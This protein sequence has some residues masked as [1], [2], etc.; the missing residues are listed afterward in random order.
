MAGKRMLVIDDEVEIGNFI[1]V[2]GERSG[3]DVSVVTDFAAFREALAA[4]EPALIVSD[5][6]M[7]QTDGIELLKFLAKSECR[8]PI[9]I[10]SGVDTRL[11]NTALRFGKANGLR[12]L[13]TLEKP[14]RVND[15]LA[16]LAALEA[17]GPSLDENGLRAAIDNH[18]L[19]L[20]YQPKIELASGRVVGAEA[21]VRW[22]IPSGGLFAPMEF[23]PLAEKT[24]LIRPLTDSVLR[25]AIR[26]C[27]E[28]SRA[29]H[30]LSAAINL[31]PAILDDPDLP[32]EIARLAAAEGLPSGRLLLE[33][34]ES[35]AMAD[36]V[37][38]MEI[39][40]R[41]RLKG[42]DLAIDD[43]GTGFS[44]LVALAR[45]PFSEIKIDKSF[46]LEMRESK[47][48]EVIV[49]SVVDLGRNLGMK[50]VAEGV[51]D[52]AVLARLAELGCDYAQGYLI[53]RPMPREQFLD[54]LGS[55]R[56]ESLASSA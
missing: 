27:A 21:L 24:K 20:H 39:L 40:A 14:L 42:F 26:A 18:N 23:I 1:K 4:G 13:G 29:G 56:P 17:E 12:M 43:F 31:S 54:W 16:V 33:V 52:A 5:L 10:V 11:R 46:V 53:G 47:E 37:R 44:S 34:T 51:E 45:M 25:Q 35:G 9:L 38:V 48:A 36:P 6:M 50:A 22:P 2:V 19:V 15:I 30:Q 41:L 8:A 49:R 3:Y 55:Y 28:W 32:D 7:P